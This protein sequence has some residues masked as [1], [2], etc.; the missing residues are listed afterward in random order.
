MMDMTIGAAARE[1]NVKV[2][3]IRFYEER[4]LLP[5]PP[6]NESGRRL[7]D[8]T[9]IARL[10]FIKHGRELGFELSEIATLLEL[11]DNPGQ[12]CGAADSIA[13]T[14]LEAVERRMSQLQALQSE[15]QRMIRDC[16]G[17]AIQTCK[18]IESLADH[19]H[20]EHERHDMT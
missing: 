12:D 20:C 5:K 19:R 6:R 2:T 10:K 14:Q 11:S 15:L 16:C 4:G 7:Y 17:G 13:R 1:T 8:E 3:T 18:V 9:H